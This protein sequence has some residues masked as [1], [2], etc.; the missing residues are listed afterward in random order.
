MRTLLLLM[1]IT[2]GNAF[3]QS[4]VQIVAAEFGLFDTSDPRATIFEPATVIPHKEGQRYGWIIQLR[5]K[6]RSVEV[7]EE[8]LL[9]TVASEAGATMSPDGQKLDIPL[10][11]RHQVSQRQLVPVRGQIIGEWAIG[12]GEP[13]GKRHL[14]VI[15]EGQ[16]GGSFEYDV[17]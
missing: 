13:T 12:P 15:I 17:R 16:V 6:K 9:P 10:P 1:L 3:A 7:R 8:Y 2:C 11:K 4:T 5:T 14:Q